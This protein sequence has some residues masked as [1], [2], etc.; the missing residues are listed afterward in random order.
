MGRFTA[1][2]YS[3]RLAVNHGPVVRA[4]DSECNGSWLESAVGFGDFVIGMRHIVQPTVRVVVVGLERS[5]EQ[6]RGDR[7]RGEQSREESR[8]EDRPGQGR[9]EEREAEEDRIGQRSGEQ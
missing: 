3:P 2:A 1:S 8:G 5:G 6:G 7:R 4:P 9:G